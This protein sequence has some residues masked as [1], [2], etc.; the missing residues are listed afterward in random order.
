MDVVKLVRGLSGVVLGSALLAVVTS[1]PQVGAASGGTWEIAVSHETSGLHDN[2]LQGVSCTSPTACTA[3]GYVNTGSSHQTLIES[4]DGSAWS[5]IPSPDPSTS[6]DSEFNGISCT[7]P[8]ACT[9]V[10]FNSTGSGTQTLDRVVGRFLLVDHSEP[11]PPSVVEQRSLRSVVH[12]PDRVHHSGIHR[13]RIRDPHRDVGRDHLVDRA[14]SES[15]CDPDLAVGRVVHGTGGVHGGGRLHHFEQPVGR[16]GIARRVVERDQLVDRAEPLGPLRWYPT[17]VGVVFES[18]CVHRR[19]L[20]P[21]GPGTYHGIPEYVH[22]GVGRVQMDGGGE[23]RTTWVLGKLAQRR[24]VHGSG[25]VH[26]SR[27]CILR[28]H[29]PDLDRILGRI[30]LVDR[31]KPN[32]LDLAEP[33][34][35]VLHRHRLARRCRRCLPGPCGPHTRAPV[36]PVRLPRGGCGR[37][38]VLLRRPVLRFDGRPQAC[39]PHRGPGDLSADRWLLGGGRRRGNLRL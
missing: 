28:V 25:G 10:G 8:T 17:H 35:R 14:E 7:S 20:L 5:I 1:A 29:L 15:R 18:V 37:G 27:Q 38:P 4:W 24:V 6:V 39:C 21:S 19:R 23:C 36:G 12:E 9:A 32:R 34:R 22:H 13:E 31:G 26:R 16:H 11:E 30:H 3:A 33:Q 2:T